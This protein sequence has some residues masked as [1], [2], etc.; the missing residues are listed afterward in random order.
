MSFIQWNLVEYENSS[1]NDKKKPFIFIVNTWDTLRL[2]VSPSV[3]SKFGFKTISFRPIHFSFE[4]K[5]TNWKKR[6]CVSSDNLSF[7]TNCIEKKKFSPSFN[8]WFAERPPKTWT[9]PSRRK[10]NAP[11]SIW[12]APM[13]VWRFSSSY[14][15]T[16]PISVRSMS[17][18][19]P[20]S[21]TLTT[22]DSRRALR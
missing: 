14:S 7:S 10:T 13:E 4:K 21:G 12:P 6:V 3:I 19:A 9:R 2:D 16:T 22:A 8:C 20:A 1:K 5:I 11:H 15:G 17:K 18:V